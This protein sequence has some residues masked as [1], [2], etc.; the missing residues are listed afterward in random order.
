MEKTCGCLECSSGCCLRLHVSP[1]CS[2]ALYL[3]MVC[4]IVQRAASPEVL[5]TAQGVR[6]VLSNCSMSLL[7]KSTFFSLASCC[8]CFKKQ[9]AADR[10]KLRLGDVVC[11]SFSES[12]VRGDGSGV[13]AP[14][15]NTSI[16]QTQLCSHC[17]VTDLT[18]Q[19]MCPKLLAPLCSATFGKGLA[20]G[21]KKVM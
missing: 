3:L 11:V 1:Y 8:S 15:P 4:S 7:P 16:N 14:G 18:S 6:H 21:S 10:L 9:V 2:Q 20:W 13:I 17:V 5:Q 19:S 12:L